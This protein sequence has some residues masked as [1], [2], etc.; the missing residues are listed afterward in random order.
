MSFKQ[1]HFL[2]NRIKLILL[3]TVL[4][5]GFIQV[6]FAQQ[7]YAVKKLSFDGNKQFSKHLLM[8][9]I[10]IRTYGFFQRHILRKKSSIYNREILETEIQRL[11]GF[12]QKEGFLSV[13]IQE[14]E[15][16]ID[17]KSKG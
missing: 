7:I 2:K 12:Y 14:P 11:T 6:L 4:F 5:F 17:E 9:Q 16:I 13:N 10:S 15:V 1:V 8:E 3:G